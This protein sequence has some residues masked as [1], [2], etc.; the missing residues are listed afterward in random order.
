MNNCISKDECEFCWFVCQWHLSDT[1]AVYW[2]SYCRIVLVLS[3]T[4][5]QQWPYTK[6]VLTFCATFASICLSASIFW[7]TNWREIVNKLWYPVVTSTLV[8]LWLQRCWSYTVAAQ[9]GLPYLTCHSMWSFVHCTD[10]YL[11]IFFLKQWVNVHFWRD[12]VVQC[13]E[14]A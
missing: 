5:M 10:C 3:R 7:K 13:C 6:I 2:C 4:L 9:V 14:K 12:K 8:I 11:F 1:P